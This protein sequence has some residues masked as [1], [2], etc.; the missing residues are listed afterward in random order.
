[1]PVLGGGGVGA[2]WGL[3]VGGIGPF[4]EKLCQFK[5]FQQSSQKTPTDYIRPN[6]LLKTRG[7][8]CMHYICIQPRAHAHKRIRIYTPIN[9]AHAHMVSDNSEKTNLNAYFHPHN[10]RVGFAMPVLVA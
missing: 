8:D 4:R 6:H 7:H 1:M 5:M 10:I 3:G 9:T 2:G